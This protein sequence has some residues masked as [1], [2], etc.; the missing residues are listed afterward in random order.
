M[1]EPWEKMENPLF[2]L[3]WQNVEEDGVTKGELRQVKQP[4]HFR[5]QAQS[6]IDQISEVCESAEVQEAFPLHLC[7]VYVVR[8][9]TI[10]A[11]RSIWWDYQEQVKVGVLPHTT[12]SMTY[13]NVVCGRIAQKQYLRT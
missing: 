3:S 2:L 6:V 13:S 5:S 10:Y 1:W 11:V 12:K 8:S 9:E 4:I 7:G